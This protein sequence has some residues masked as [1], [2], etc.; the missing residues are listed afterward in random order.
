MPGGEWWM[1]PISEIKRKVFHHLT[2]VYILVYMVV[3]RW[4]SVWLFGAI[5]L[6]V[7]TIEFLRLRRPELNAWLLEKFKD[8]SR[9]SEIMSPSGIFWGLLGSW[10][11]MLIF[12]NPKIV[13]AAIGFLTFGDA[14]ASL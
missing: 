9:E 7:G 5:L 10:L 8:I 4:V 1:V 11:T 6:A 13:V 2:L 12:T 14:A 3:P